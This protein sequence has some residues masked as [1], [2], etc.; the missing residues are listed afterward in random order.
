MKNS[1]LHEIA[2]FAAGLV[3]A[4][5]LWLLWFSQQHVHSI[6]FFGMTVTSDMLLPSLIFDIAL[7]IV[8]VHYGWHVGKIPAV[9][10]RTYVFV[11]GIIF[12]IVAIGHIW[13]IFTGADLMLGDWDVP[14]WLSWFGVAV[15]VYLSY[16]SF[17]LAA[18]IKGK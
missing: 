10:E 12:A 1:S 3:A 15:T 7:F 17:H 2:K 6:A 9:R 13:R 4:D 5:F 11:V 14:V 8:L 16:M 18:R